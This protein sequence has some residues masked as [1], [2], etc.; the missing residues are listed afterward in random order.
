MRGIRTARCAGF[1]LSLFSAS[2]L[3]GQKPADKPLPDIRQLMTEVAEHQKQVEKLREDYTYTAQTVTQDLDSKGQVKKTETGEFEEFFVHGR[4]I[5]RRIK[6][7]GKPLDGEEQQKETERV[8]KAVEKAENPKSEEKEEENELH[9]VKLL[10]IVDASQPR[11]ENFRGRATIVCDFVGRKDAKAHGLGEDLFKKL[12]GTV[13]I[14][15]ADREVTRL[16]AT[17]YDNVRIGGGLLANIQKGT[18]L[19]FDQAKI[20]GEIWLPIDS[21]GT[22]DARLM[23]FKGI[24]QHIVEHDSN[25]QRFHVEALQNKDVKVVT[26]KKP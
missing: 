2:L 16:E 15:E 25:Y 12:R 20:N 18:Y 24:R 9:L 10:E 22:L 1:L 26:D 21:E 19:T 7:D 5:W 23:V 14:D 13:W 3:H 11:R 8:T 4:L 6:K 17:F